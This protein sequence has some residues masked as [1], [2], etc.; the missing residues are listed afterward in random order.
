[1]IIYDIITDGYNK[2]LRIWGIQRSDPVHWGSVQVTTAQ[3]H[4]ASLKKKK[5]HNTS[6]M[7]MY[8]H[9]FC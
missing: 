4:K 3:L 7:H 2:A 1:M 8:S 9:T 6:F 5:E